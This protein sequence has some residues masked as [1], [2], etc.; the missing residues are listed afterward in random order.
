M[1]PVHACLDTK[2]NCFVSIGLVG[3]RGSVQY[4]GILKLQTNRLNQQV[5]KLCH[6]LRKP[7]TKM[8]Q[9]IQYMTKVYGQDQWPKEGPE[10]LENDPPSRWSAVSQMKHNVNQLAYPLILSR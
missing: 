2:Q 6:C 10:T 7:V 4:V 3:T 5:N 8:L 9:M 1:E